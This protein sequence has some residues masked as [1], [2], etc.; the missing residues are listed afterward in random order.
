M[1]FKVKMLFK[2]IILKETLLKKNIMKINRTKKIV[3]INYGHI[4]LQGTFK[5]EVYHNQLEMVKD[6]YLVRHSKSAWHT[7]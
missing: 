7:L 3:I 1:D 6:Q 2:I 4:Y 5:N